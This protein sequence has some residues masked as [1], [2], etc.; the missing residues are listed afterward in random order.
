MNWVRSV[1][2]SKTLLANKYRKQTAKLTRQANRLVSLT[3]ISHHCE[4]MSLE[5]QQINNLGRLY[6]SLNLHIA[7]MNTNTTSRKN[8]RLSLK[9]NDLFSFP[10]L[11]NFRFFSFSLVINFLRRSHSFILR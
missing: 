10:Y 3:L 5:V 8:G 9:F 2:N 4:F 11:G 1:N 7:K 6:T